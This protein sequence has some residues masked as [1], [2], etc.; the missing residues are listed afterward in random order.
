[1]AWSWQSGSRSAWWLIEWVEIIKIGVGF[2]EWVEI[3]VSLSGGLRTAWVLL[4]SLW[5]MAVEISVVHGFWSSGLWVMV[6]E[7]GVVRGFWLSSGD[8][9]GRSRGEWVLIVRGFWW[10]GFR[11]SFAM[12]F[13]WGKSDWLDFGWILDS[14]W[15]DFGFWIW[16]G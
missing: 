11:W 8:R 9:V 15:L 12:D 13:W 1:M 5:V 14:A 6:V 2:V 7:I 16:I 10:G 4:S 3:G